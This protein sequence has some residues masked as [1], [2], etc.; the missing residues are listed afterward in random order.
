MDLETGP[1]LFGFEHGEKLLLATV[2]EHGEKPLSETK[3]A[4]KTDPFMEGVK[5]MKTYFIIGIIFMLIQFTCTWILSKI[6][7]DYK[8]FVDT[9][10]VGSALWQFLASALLWPLVLALNILYAIVLLKKKKRF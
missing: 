8:D 2:I 10:T 3:L 5:Y 7:E 1:S 4:R 9:I 6:R